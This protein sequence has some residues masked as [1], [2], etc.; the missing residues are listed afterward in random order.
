[1]LPLMPTER[2]PPS[3][4]QLRSSWSPEPSGC[5][6][7][8]QETCPLGLLLLRL[9]TYWNPSC[10]SCLLAVS[11][12]GKAVEDGP[13]AWALHPRGGTTPAGF[14]L[15]QLSLLSNKMKSKLYSL[16]AQ[17]TTAKV[18]QGIQVTARAVQTRIKMLLPF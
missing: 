13:R 10:A 8:L 16:Q 5:E 9:A 2:H 1:M 14:S 7:K 15:T 17:F 11:T 6:L 12:L 18:L 3:M 4:P